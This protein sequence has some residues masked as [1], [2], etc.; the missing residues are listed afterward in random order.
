MSSSLLFDVFRDYDPDN[1]LL[2][3]SYQE[4]L[5]LQ[6]EEFRLRKALKRISSQTLVVK[7][8]IKP[9]PFCFPIL[10]DSLG[11][12]KFSTESIEDRVAKMTLQFSKF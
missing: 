9:S 5:T 6:L 2:K 4:A 7:K 11:R 8:I 3:Q 12:E 1:L 10:V